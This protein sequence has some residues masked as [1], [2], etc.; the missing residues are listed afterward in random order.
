MLTR[1]KVK[2]FKSLENV[3]VVF[4][5]FTCIAGINGVGKSNLF[6]A[7]LF[8]K[9][10][11]DQSL[12]IMK[13]A[14]LVRNRDGSNRTD[15]GSLF[16][17]TVST[18]AKEME[19]EAEFIVNDKVIDDYRREASPKVTYL[20]YKLVLKYVPPTSSTSEGI[21]LAH[22][23]LT[24]IQKG[25]AR[26]RLGFT[27]SREFFNSVYKGGSKIN[28]IYTDEENGHPVLKIRQDQKG[29][30]PITIPLLNTERTAL[31]GINSI[32]RPTALAA[33][34]EIQSWILLQL[35]PSALRRPDNFVSASKVSATGEHLPATLFR[36]E[37]IPGKTSE[38]T[39]E[40][41][42]LLPE[43][44]NVS[45]DIDEPRQ[46]K[47]LFLE[48]TSGIKHEARALSDGTLRF[49]ALSI[50]GADVDNG[51]VICL[52]EPE[53]GIHPVRISAMIE[54]LYQMSVAPDYAIDSVENP[55]R[56]VIINTHSPLVIQQIK[57]EDLIVS[58]PFKRD[59]AQISRFTA[60]A[61]TWR[62]EAMCSE[63]S[64]PIGY[65]TLLDYLTVNE[66]LE[67]SDTK[68]DTVAHYL[69]HQQQLF[70]Q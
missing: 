30:N 1:L 45:V 21:E 50:I 56:Q 55:L 70:V 19:F 29:G 25:E 68:R 58:Q 39:N 67:E 40:L 15:I 23:E 17:R 4:G 18:Q 28:F 10:M 54:L 27:H 51:G 66:S 32:D 7:I 22:E 20:R 6:D 53:N 41:A 9:D 64:P 59:G 2:G 12:T 8:L 60:V 37:K 38:I 69:R 48:T 16:S 31:S 33:K 11:T 57:T 43:V 47:T 3:D 42:H 5:P 63:T 35:E 46:S 13:A 52:E 24:F 14:N 49:L 36:L 44:A 61:E 34:R 62:Q 26:Q 65:G